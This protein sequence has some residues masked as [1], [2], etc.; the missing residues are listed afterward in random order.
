M[1]LGGRTTII[2]LVSWGTSQDL[3]KHFLRGLIEFAFTAP[4]QKWPKGRMIEVHFP[5]KCLI[6]LKIN[7]RIGEPIKYYT[8]IV[9]NNNCR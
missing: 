2:S 7:F 1:V 8:K 6:I 5:N 4:I 3:L 9:L